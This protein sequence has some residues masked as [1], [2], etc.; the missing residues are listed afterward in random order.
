M[1]VMKA[2]GHVAI[3]TTKAIKRLLICKG[4][5]MSALFFP[6]A[7]GPLDFRPFVFSFLLSLTLHK[8]VATQL[9]RNSSTQCPRLASKP[10]AL[11]ISRFS[12]VQT[13]YAY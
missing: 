13:F 8:N 11:R 9:S 10:P 1:D 2:L 7:S 5:V 4:I 6:F 3:V 12:F